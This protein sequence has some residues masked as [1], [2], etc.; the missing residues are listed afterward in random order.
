MV[1]VKLRLHSLHDSLDVGTRAEKDRNVSITEMQRCDRQAREKGEEKRCRALEIKVI[2]P[3]KK[4]TGSIPYMKRICATHQKANIIN[5]SFP[6]KSATISHEALPKA[7]C[8]YTRDLATC[9]KTIFFHRKKTP[10]FRDLLPI[11]GNGSA[12]TAKTIYFH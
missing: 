9:A 10:N 5:G 11:R 8:P 4:F 7:A 2:A 1:V 3:R 12:H 6:N